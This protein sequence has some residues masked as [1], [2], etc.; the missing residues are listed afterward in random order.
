MNARNPENSPEYKIEEAVMNNHQL[1]GYKKIYNPIR[2]VLLYRGAGI[3]DLVLLPRESKHRLVLVEAKHSSNP[4]S[5][6]KVIGQLL[7]YYSYALN[8]GENAIELLI[9]F[10]EKNP[11]LARG[12]K[13]VTPQQLSGGKHR[14]YAMPE[15]LKGKQFLQPDEIGLF[16]A[17][18]NKIEPSLSM[19]VSKLRRHHNLNIG[20]IQVLPDGSINAQIHD[21]L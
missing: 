8:F 16:V 19:I 18:D 14:N 13:R 17:I 15:M 6:E 7:K 2:R 9:N 10:S 21:L 12:I 4:E 11:V 1:L 5:G 20:I 3:V